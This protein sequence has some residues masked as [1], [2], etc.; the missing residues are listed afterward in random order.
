[1]SRVVAYPGGD[2]DALVAAA[3]LVAAGRVLES[4]KVVE[5]TKLLPPAAA[6]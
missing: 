3:R 4:E 6:H 2:P 1:V 5:L